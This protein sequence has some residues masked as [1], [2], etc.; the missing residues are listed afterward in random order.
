MIPKRIIR[1]C[2]AEIVP[3]QEELWA[4]TSALHP[5]WEMVTLRDPCPEEWFP[6]TAHLWNLCESG[7][8]RAG[9]KRLE[10]L[11]H[12]GGFYID[13]D[14]KI[15]KSLTP[16]AWGRAAIAAYEDAWIIPDAFLAAPP[17]HPAIEACLSLACDRLKGTA[18]RERN[19]WT[20]DQGTWSTGPG[21]TTK[22][23]GGGDYHTLVLPVESFYPVHYDP[24]ETLQ[25][26]LREYQPGP[27]TYGM[28]LWNWSWR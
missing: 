25:Q 14:F 9:L 3:W 18:Y 15:F 10:Y 13:S 17:K 6:L 7:A 2:P 8:Q 28:H 26:R 1:T 20:D 12:N 23:F 27:R 11:Y 21:V 24:R 4:E 16:L 19:D 22:I 5:G